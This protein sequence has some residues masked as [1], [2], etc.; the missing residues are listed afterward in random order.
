MEVVEVAEFVIEL[1]QIFW[2]GLIV[3]FVLEV[4]CFWKVLIQQFFRM[5][6]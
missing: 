2:I 5:S 3:A 6:V 1:F 4:H